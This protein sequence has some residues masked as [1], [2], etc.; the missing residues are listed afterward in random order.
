MYINKELIES[1]NKYVGQFYD[2][3]LELGNTLFSVYAESPTA[4]NEFEAQLVARVFKEDGGEEVEAYLD[5]YTNILDRRT[6]FGPQVNRAG[7][8][9]ARYDITPANGTNLY[10]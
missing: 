7:S 1:A 2:I 10:S 6:S 8:W 3:D 9:V 5:M 4:I